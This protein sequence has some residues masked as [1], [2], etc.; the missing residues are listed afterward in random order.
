MFTRIF[1]SGQIKAQEKNLTAF[2]VFLQPTLTCLFDFDA[3]LAFRG[4]VGLN[5]CKLGK[6]S[7]DFLSLW[8]IW[9]KLCICCHNWKAYLVVFFPHFVSCDSDKLRTVFPIIFAIFAKYR[10]VSGSQDFPP[11]WRPWSR[12]HRFSRQIQFRVPQVVF[13]WNLQKHFWFLV[14]AIWFAIS[15]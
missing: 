8:P 13:H 4:D 7:V 2:S 3:A 11:I 15:S 1:S 5:L 14:K 6:N 9:S 12:L 10:S